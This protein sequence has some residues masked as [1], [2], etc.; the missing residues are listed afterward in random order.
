MRHAFEKGYSELRLLLVT[1]SK[2]IRWVNFPRHTSA[3]SM[4][5]QRRGE[6]EVEYSIPRSTN[7]S[8]G[9]YD[10]V[11]LLRREAAMV[12]LPKAVHGDFLNGNEALAGVIMNI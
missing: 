11:L 4:R 3:L 10:H 9:C 12:I 2:F 7:L 1:S 6:G 8:H 5:V